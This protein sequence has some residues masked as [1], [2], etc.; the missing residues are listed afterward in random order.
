MKAKR[1]MSH[2][3]LI[4][5][6]VTNCIFSFSLHLAFVGNRWM[7]EP[8]EPEK[9]YLD[10][11]KYEDKYHWYDEYGI[12]HNGS[13]LEDIEN[14]NQVRERD[15][16]RKLNKWD[17]SPKKFFYFCK[18]EFKIYPSQKRYDELKT[19]G[20]SNQRVSCWKY[21]Q[22]GKAI[23]GKCVFFDTLNNIVT[24]IEKSINVHTRKLKDSDL[25][26]YYY[27]H[28]L[29][30]KYPVEWYDAVISEIVK[31]LK[32]PDDSDIALQ[33]STGIEYPFPYSSLLRK[34]KGRIRKATVIMC[35][36]RIECAYKPLVEGIERT[37]D[38]R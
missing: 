31:Y 19:I 8:K 15:Y 26:P 4:F 12:R 27:L 6:E 10:L 32:P 30:K 9:S 34:V 24:E 3:K 1:T 16:Q 2:A 5:E 37:I 17:S 21:Y 13:M 36:N 18:A 25:L 11:S 7:Y 22:C 35:M 20:K 38:E 14:S 23:D 33:N 29:I 28:E